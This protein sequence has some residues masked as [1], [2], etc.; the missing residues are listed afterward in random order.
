MCVCVRERIDGSGSGLFDIAYGRDNNKDRGGKPAEAW[1]ASG[2]TDA[3]RGVGGGNNKIAPAAPA[4]GVADRATASAP[5]Q[6]TGLVGKM[7][8]IVVRQQTKSEIH[9]MGTGSLRPISDAKLRSAGAAG[10]FPPTTVK[11]QPP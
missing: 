6:T 7:R 3:A 8:S 1:S 10:L 5:T 2:A 4:A 11:S 9:A